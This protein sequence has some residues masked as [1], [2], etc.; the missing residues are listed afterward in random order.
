MKTWFPTIFDLYTEVQIRYQL[1]D[2]LA[3]YIFEG[4]CFCGTSLNSGPRALSKE[5]IDCRN[6]VAGICL[7]AV[8]GSFNHRT[9]GH[10]I[11]REP[12]AILEVMDGD[13]VIIPSGSVTHANSSLRPGEWRMSLVQY[14]SGALFRRLFYGGLAPPAPTTKA[15]KAILDYEGE[16]RW[17]QCWGF[18]PKLSDLLTAM[19]TGTMPKQDVR[20]LIDRDECLVIRNVALRT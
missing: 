12:K 8:I 9:S 7:I 4:S 5:H 3:N 20:G 2:A 13:F 14:T 17:K 15:G 19:E 11:L 18:F 6:L 1:F 16:R 10:L